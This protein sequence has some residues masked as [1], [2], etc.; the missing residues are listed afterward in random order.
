MNVLNCDNFVE[1]CRNIRKLLPKALW[2]AFPFSG[3][4]WT[5]SLYT[6]SNPKDEN[7]L[8]SPKWVG[9][10]TPP[11]LV[12]EISDAQVSRPTKI[13][14]TSKWIWINWQLHPSLLK[15]KKQGASLKDFKRKGEN[16]QGLAKSVIFLFIWLQHWKCFSTRQKLDFLIIFIDYN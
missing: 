9:K 5:G 12:K 14:K 4:S 2:I 10:K 16:T 11:T 13:T 7:L 3:L 1:T 6:L 8:K 15:K